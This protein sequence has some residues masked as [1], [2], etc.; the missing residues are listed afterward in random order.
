[1]KGEHEESSQDKMRDEMKNYD[2]SMQLNQNLLV[3]FMPKP[4]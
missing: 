1:M 2:E 4:T 3:N